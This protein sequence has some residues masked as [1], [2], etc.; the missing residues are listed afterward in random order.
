MIDIKKIRQSSTH[1]DKEKP[2][3]SKAAGFNLEVSTRSDQ[4][5]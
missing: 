2:G 5:A 3:S 1:C 4:K